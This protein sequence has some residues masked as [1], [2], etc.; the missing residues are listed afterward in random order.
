MIPKRKEVKQMPI[1]EKKKITNNRY[2]A[3][4]AQ[5]NLKPPKAEA[6]KIKAAAAQMGESVQGYIL[7]A[8]R[9]RMARDGFT[10]PDGDDSSPGE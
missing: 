4:C 5:I 9:E 1:N 6:E 2:L 8:T 7:T 10:P 3:K